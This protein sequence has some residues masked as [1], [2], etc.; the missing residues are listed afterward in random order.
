M[1]RFWFVFDFMN[2]RTIPPGL[3]IGCG[4]TAIN[5]SDAIS[6]LEQI[7]FKGAEF[8]PIREVIEDVNIDTLD[9]GHVL[10]NMNPPNIRGIWFPKGYEK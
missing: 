9:S 2:Y 8:P 1:K 6:L 10:P 7:V 5:Y 3:V 4:I